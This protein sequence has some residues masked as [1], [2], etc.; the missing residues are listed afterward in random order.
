MTMLNLGTCPYHSSL[1]SGK[2]YDN[3]GMLRIIKNEI[4]NESMPHCKGKF[5]RPI[6]FNGFISDLLV[7]K[8][9]PL[10]NTELTVS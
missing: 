7:A 10:A 5:Q 6:L 4:K 2:L 8:E 1:L 9:V 3:T